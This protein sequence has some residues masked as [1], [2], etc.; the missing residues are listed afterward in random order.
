V[1]FM[2]RRRVGVTS[3]IAAGCLGVAAALLAAAPA[4]AA[5]VLTVSATI[6][7]GPTQTPMSSDPSNPTLVA[8]GSRQIVLTV[9][10]G[11]A[12]TFT[13]SGLT[14]LPTS[15]CDQT[16][17]APGASATCSGPIAVN[18]GL[19]TQPYEATGAFAAD[20]TNIG[21]QASVATS[22][23]G[24]SY[25]LQT[26]LYGDFPPPGGG[27]AIY[28]D[29]R[30]LSLPLGYYPTFH[31]GYF[32]G[33]NVGLTGL[34]PTGFATGCAPPPTIIAAGA[35]IPQSGCTFTLAAPVTWHPSSVVVTTS[36]TLNFA[37]GEGECSTNVRT[38][39][40][41]ERLTVN[42]FGFL[43]G[44]S[45]TAL[46]N[47]APAPLGTE[48][49]GATGDFSFSFVVPSALAPG[50]HRVEL[51]LGGTTL[52]MTD[53]FTVTAG[54]APTGWDGLPMLAAASGVLLVGSALVVLGVLRRRHTR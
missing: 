14:A 47:S 32:N 46:L 39:G 10:N 37:P 44:I 5:G 31:V 17:L 22:I 51:S 27:T 4:Q 13:L 42:C 3:A 21:V 16:V 33:S 38:I 11:T 15:T 29:T 18:S 36:A 53:P 12:D 50:F 48:N 52:T 20:P 6:A 25:D 40:Q 8:V 34:T 41:G 28:T 30:F 35:T 1:G 2:S 43:P 54:L 9:D 26:L 23:F 7:V 45:V 19:L 49:T 24:V